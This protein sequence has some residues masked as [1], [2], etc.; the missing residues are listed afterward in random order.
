MTE[1]VR[2]GAQIQLNEN[3]LKYFVPKI[4]LKS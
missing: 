3:I 4:A 2:N 1:V